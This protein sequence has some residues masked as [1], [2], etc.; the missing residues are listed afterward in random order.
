M[1]QRVYLIV[2]GHFREDI[3]R[4]S[5]EESIR[6]MTV[7]KWIEFNRSTDENNHMLAR[8]VQWP[9]LDRLEG[10]NNVF[11]LLDVLQKRL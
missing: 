6:D 8:C 10:F 4:I 7:D 2:C 1:V 3:I 5:T 9:R 11:P